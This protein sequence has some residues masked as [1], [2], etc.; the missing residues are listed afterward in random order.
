MLSEKAGVNASFERSYAAK[1]RELLNAY[2]TYASSATDSCGPEQN[3][4][5][6]KRDLTTIR[7]AGFQYYLV[8]PDFR[9]NACFNSM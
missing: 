5:A 7:K 6:S 9:V 2:A 8:N 3:A 1:M 4:S